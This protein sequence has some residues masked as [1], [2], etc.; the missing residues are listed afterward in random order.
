[1]NA[2]VTLGETVVA[3]Y[4]Q[5][6]SYLV[7]RS[8]PAIH[9]VLRQAQ[10]SDL[11]GD[12]PT[13]LRQVGQAGAYDILVALAPTIAKRITRPQF[14]GF[15]TD[16]AMAAGDYDPEAACDPTFDEIV[17]AFKVVGR[18]NGMENLLSVGR[19]LGK[20][21][22]P[23]LIRAEIN[24]AV[25]NSIGSLNSPRTSGGSDSTSSTTSPPTSPVSEASPS[26]DST[27]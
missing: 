6:V 2:E 7:N 9:A 3:V 24:L 19:L 10:V 11:D 21:I 4:P 16:E 14:C 12:L 15:V 23:R 13:V 26:T 17:E 22:D 25:A 18:V 20:A 1:M 5:R 27:D 8:I